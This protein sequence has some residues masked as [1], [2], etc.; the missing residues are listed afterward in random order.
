[1]SLVRVVILQRRLVVIDFLPRSHFIILLYPAGQATAATAG[2]A[3]LIGAALDAGMESVAA[4]YSATNAFAIEI[5]LYNGSELFR[6]PNNPTFW[7]SINM[8]LSGDRIGLPDPPAPFFELAGEA[9]YGFTFIGPTPEEVDEAL[10]DLN[11]DSSSALDIIETLHSLGTLQVVIKGET[12]ASLLLSE[13]PVIGVLYPDLTVTILEQNAF[14]STGTEE[15]AVEDGGNE[16]NVTVYPGLYLFEGSA[17]AHEFVETLAMCYFD[18]SGT[19]L[20]RSVVRFIFS[21]RCDCTS[22]NSIP[23]FYA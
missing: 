11:N 23:S 12:S 8:G 10:E 7:V 9:I 5:W 21:S 3:T 1:M 6:Y 13:I 16:K 14:L 22:H 2:I 17:A 18:F 19:I 20:V 15:I 4:G